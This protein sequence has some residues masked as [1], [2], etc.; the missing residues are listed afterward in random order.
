MM[1]IAAK[2]LWFTRSLDMRGVIGSEFWWLYFSMIGASGFLGATILDSTPLVMYIIG[3]M[4]SPRLILR[5]ALEGGFRMFNEL[6][7]A[8]LVDWIFGS[9]M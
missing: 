1:S 7:S 2:L 9:L 8:A 5:S 6:I 4:F 3:S